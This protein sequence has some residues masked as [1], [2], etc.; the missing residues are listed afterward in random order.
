M[1]NEKNNATPLVSLEDQFIAL[2]ETSSSIEVDDRFY[3]NYDNTVHSTSGDDEEVVI[4]F[5]YEE[6]KTDVI[7]TAEEFNEIELSSDGKTWSIGG[8]NI[9]FY[10]VIP[11][12]TIAA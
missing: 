4:Q 2:F 1:S 7:I 3:R 6:E 8:Y 11:I 9:Q 12:T 5:S 10:S